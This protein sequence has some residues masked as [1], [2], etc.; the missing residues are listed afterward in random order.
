MDHCGENRL[1]QEKE[2][3]NT[4]SSRIIFIDTECLYFLVPNVIID[5][6]EKM[7]FLRLNLTSYF[8]ITFSSSNSF[9]LDA[10]IKDEF[11]SIRSTR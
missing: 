9:V 6:E 2:I 4:V 8:R 1:R 5:Q 3:L 7:I 10:L 11:A